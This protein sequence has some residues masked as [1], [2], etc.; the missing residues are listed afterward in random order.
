MEISQKLEHRLII[1]PRLQQSLKL[2]TLNNLEIEQAIEEEL[3][4]NPLLEWEPGQPSDDKAEDRSPD[5]LDNINWQEALSST[6]RERYAYEAAEEI[7]P[8]ATVQVPPV[9]LSEHLL[10]QLEVADT[11]DR[12]F[13]IA[14]SIISALDRDGYLR[15]GTAALATELGEDENEV[16]RVLTEIVQ[17]MDPPG[18]AARDLRECLLIQ[19]REGDGEAPALAGVIIEKHLDLL[20]NRSDEKL[21]KAV[22]ATPEEVAVAIDYIKDLEPRPG[23]AFGSENNPALV[24]DIRVD[25]VGDAVEI[26]FLDERIGRLYIS[27]GYR[28]LLAGGEGLDREAERFLRYRL[29]AAASFIRAIHQRRKTLEKVVGAVFERQRAFLA[30][31]E[32]GLKPLTMEDVANQLGFHVSTVSRATASKVVDTPMGIFPLKYFFTGSVASSEGEV[33]V[34]RVKALLEDIITDEDKGA[35]LSDE[36]LASELQKRGVRVA[37]RTVAKY[38]KLL[39]IPGKYERKIV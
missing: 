38:R 26:T 22:N 35:P 9:T 8:Y 28:E 5:R 31:G 20:A 6:P 18:A 21:L 33:S 39:K 1:S 29:K 11:T 16:E 13:E 24:P 4:T 15:L 17:I 23:R 36:S 25:L 19:W 3:E 30:L 10:R 14:A 2:L 32:P 34:E 37:R 27:P 12:D 7:D